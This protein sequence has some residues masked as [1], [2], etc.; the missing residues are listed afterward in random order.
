ME[1]VGVMD[2]SRAVMEI[3]A[4]KAGMPFCEGRWAA[5][6]RM[7][8]VLSKKMEMS[9]QMNAEGWRLVQTPSYGTVPESDCPLCGRMDD[10]ET[11]LSVGGGPL[12][13]SSVFCNGCPMHDVIRQRLATEKA[14]PAPSSPVLVL[15][16]IDSVLQGYNRSRHLRMDRL[17][18]DDFRLDG[19]LSLSPVVPFPRT[20]RYWEKVR[21][22]LSPG[23][24]KAFGHDVPIVF[25]KPLCRIP[26]VE[27]RVPEGLAAAFS[28]LEAK[29][30]TPVVA[31]SFDGSL[32]HV[33]ISMG[34]R[35]DFQEEMG[36]RIWLSMYSSFHLERAVEVVL[37]RRSPSSSPI[38]R[39]RYPA[40]VC[41]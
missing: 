19:A 29:L 31:T 6:A 12:D 33:R 14:E 37:E 4:E 30:G 34:P 39:R 10:E 24:R 41:D 17:V 16:K 11:A 28:E 27:G 5:E 9:R 23:L 20:R 8:E 1:E 18:I 22:D 38:R 2:L 40:G 7:L 3:L 35:A 13:G 36:A 32:L 15:E 26:H 21:K 25:A